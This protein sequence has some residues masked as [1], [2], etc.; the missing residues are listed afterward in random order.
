MSDPLDNL[1]AAPVA[2][3]PDD[4]FSARVVARMAQ[5][6]RRE[7]W[8]T[9]AAIG[10]GAV[11]AVLILPL[12]GIAADIARL[13]PLL[14]SATPLAATGALLALTFSFEKLI[15]DRLG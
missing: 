1:L 8:I 13:L 10:L 5:E 7:R 9:Y 11:P 12:P 2:D 6:R 14:A 3:I 15:R 4:G